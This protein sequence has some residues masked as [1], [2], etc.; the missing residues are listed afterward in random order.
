MT[1]TTETSHH[2]LPQKPQVNASPWVTVAR[3]AAKLPDP[4]ANLAK[5]M[6]QVQT[7]RAE[8]DSPKEDQRLF[9]RISQENQ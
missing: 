5:L 2:V 9:L 3:K 7:K 1:K 4:P 8:V 6:P